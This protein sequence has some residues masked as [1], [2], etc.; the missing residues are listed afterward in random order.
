M[1]TVVSL[2]RRGEMF[3]D[4]RRDDH[5]LRLSW[6]PEAGVLVVSIWQADRCVATARIA[7]SPCQPPPPI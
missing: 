5:V 6:H 1:A 2:P 4:A 3:L 7:R